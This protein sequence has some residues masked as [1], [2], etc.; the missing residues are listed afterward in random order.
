MNLTE[1]FGVF[2]WLKR[3]FPYANVVEDNM[4]SVLHFC[5][6]WSLFES[7]VC[8]RHASVGKMKSFTKGLNK[9]ESLKQRDFDPYLLY[10]QKRYLNHGRTNDRFDKLRISGMNRELVES[11]L[12]K[13]ETKNSSVILALL[14]IVYRL[15]NN[16]FHGEKPIITL[17]NQSM[18]FNVANRFLAEVLDLHKNTT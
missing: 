2:D 4:S 14:I 10:F 7:K 5:L 18:N 15:R 8:E 6:M 12:K 9:T 11:V 13:E 3:Y 17:H 16:L 1:E